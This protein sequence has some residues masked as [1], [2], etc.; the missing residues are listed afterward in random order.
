ME[1]SS[2]NSRPSL[3]SNSDKLLYYLRGFVK[4]C[5]VPVFY[6]VILFD[7]KPNPKAK[8]RKKS[9]KNEQGIPIFY[10]STCLFA[11]STIKS[12]LWYLPPQQSNWDL[13]YSVFL[14]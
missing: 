8:R 5:L 14:A 11:L 2:T 13:F 10:S 4:Y 1:T 12:L 9:A 7:Q 6:T 3:K